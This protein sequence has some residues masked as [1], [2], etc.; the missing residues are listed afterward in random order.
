MIEASVG[1]VG[2]KFEHAAVG[3]RRA[4]GFELAA[5][6]RGYGPDIGHQGVDIFKHCVVDTLHHI[7]GRVIF[8][9]ADY[10][11]VVY[12]ALAERLDGLHGSVNIEALRYLFKIL[13]H[14]ESKIRISRAQNK[15]I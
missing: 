6:V 5:Y 14:N 11:G 3:V 9:C 12:Q 1:F 4:G 13:F 2:Y 10:E 7:V 15:F 8:G